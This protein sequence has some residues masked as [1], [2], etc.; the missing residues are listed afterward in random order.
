MKLSQARCR[1]PGILRPHTRPRPQPSDT[2]GSWQSMQR[3]TNPHRRMPA[4][5]AASEQPIEVTVQQSPAAAAKRRKP[6]MRTEFPPFTTVRSGGT[7]DLRL[8]D[9][10]PP[11][12]AD[13]TASSL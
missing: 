5:V 11:H 9:V 10:R 2:S 8:Y 13:M 4:H 12:S 3:L 7:Y 6:R 1:H